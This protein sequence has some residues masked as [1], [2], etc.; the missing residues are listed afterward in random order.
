MAACIDPGALGTGS[1]GW[2]QAATCSWGAP[3]AY[4]Q[5][6][7]GLSRTEGRVSRRQ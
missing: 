6:A 4:G 1:L 7:R 2:A 3:D 5:S